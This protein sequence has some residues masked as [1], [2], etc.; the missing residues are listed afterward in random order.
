MT[1]NP[2]ADIP[3]GARWLHSLVGDVHI[4]PLGVL[5]PDLRAMVYEGVPAGT[6]VVTA[7]QALGNAALQGIV[8]A[9]M[10]ASST[11]GNPVVLTREQLTEILLKAL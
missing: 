11:K 7:E 9:T 6:A 1:G 5:C 4:P 2:A 8:T 3:E 10:G